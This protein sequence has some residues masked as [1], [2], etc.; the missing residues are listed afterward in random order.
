MSMMK[1]YYSI[2]LLFLSLNALAFDNCSDKGPQISDEVEELAEAVDKITGEIASKVLGIK[3]NYD[4]TGTV[5]VLA[6]DKGELL[7]LRLDYKDSKGHLMQQTKTV[8]EFNKG[9][10]VAF[11]MEGQI[12]KP[13]VLKAKPGTNISKTNGGSFTFSLLTDNDPIKYA[14]YQLS[15]VKVGSSWKVMKSD[16]VVTGTIISPNISWSMTWEGTFKSATFQ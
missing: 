11:E 14:H 15:L 1:Q 7:G 3:V 16:K 12:N 8:E 13:L 2:I 9:G 5:K 6:N 4:G 10:S